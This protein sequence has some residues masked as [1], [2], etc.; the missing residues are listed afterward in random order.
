MKATGWWN[1][2]TRFLPSGMSTAVLPPSARLPGRESGRHVDDGHAPRVVRGAKPGGIGESPAAMARRFLRSYV[3]VGQGAAG[4][5]MTWRRWRS[6]HGQQVRSTG[7]PRPL[8]RRDLRA[9]V[10]RSV[11]R[12]QNRSRAS[13]RLAETH[14]SCRECVADLDPADA[15]PLDARL[16][17]SR[18]SRDGSR[19]AHDRVQRLPCADLEC[20]R[21]RSGRAPSQLLEPGQGIVAGDEWTIGAPGQPGGQNLGRTVK[22]DG[23]G[24]G[25][26]ASR[27][28]GSITVPPS[29]GDDSAQP[30]IGVG[31]PQRND[32]FAIRGFG[33]RLALF[34]ED[35]LDRGVPVRPTTEVV[36]GP[37]TRPC[38]DLPAADRRHSCRC[39]T[40]RPGPGPRFT[41]LSAGA[42]PP[43]PCVRP[44]LRTGSGEGRPR[45]ALDSGRRCRA[46]AIESPPNFSRAKSASVRQTI[47]SAR[48]RWRARRRCRCAQ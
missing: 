8:E 30:G 14:G 28:R 7:Q 15:V 22:P 12:R 9:A 3:G 23:S 32:G 26:T 19:G 29:R 11:A 39:P 1:A 18:A 4:L 27:C 5:S 46:S 31:R 10:P 45:A 16:Q 38:G 20:R 17:P 43:A 42:A 48:P 47:A 40:D 13:T 36:P 35:R 25:T 44:R 33:I 2:P 34:G 37:R 41:S 24:R 21:V 6:R